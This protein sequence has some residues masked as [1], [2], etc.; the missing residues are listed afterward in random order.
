L[1]K[2]EVDRDYLAPTILVLELFSDD[3]D[4]EL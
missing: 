3:T 1:R 2:K 4:Y